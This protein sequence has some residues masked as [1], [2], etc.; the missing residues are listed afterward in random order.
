MA[1][2]HST[3]MEHENETIKR[4]IQ[5]GVDKGAWYMLL[6]EDA[7]LNDLYPV[8]LTPEESL[9]EIR[10]ICKKN[11]LTILKEVDLSGYKDLKKASKKSDP[12]PLTPHVVRHNLISDDG[13]L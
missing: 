11:K 6:F 2:H 4:W 9:D 10:D 3:L 5:E 7:Y 12:F 1:K 13:K 8:Y